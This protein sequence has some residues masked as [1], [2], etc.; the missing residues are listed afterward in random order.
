MNLAQCNYLITDKELL[1][2]HQCLNHFDNII[3]GSKIWIFCNHKNLTFGS[4]MIHQSQR[5]LR[6][7]IDTSND[8]NAEFLCITGAENLRVDAMKNIQQKGADDDISKSRLR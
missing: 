6:Q 7:K 5:V 1:V 2:A 4:T 8:Y 3:Q